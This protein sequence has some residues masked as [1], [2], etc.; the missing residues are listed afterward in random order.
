MECS[1]VNGSIAKIAGDNGIFPLVLY[2]EGHTRSDRHLC[3]DDTVPSI[4]TQFIAPHM[5]G[6]AFA[7][8]TPCNFAEKF[9][10]DGPWV[11]PFYQSMTMFPVAT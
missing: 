11:H 6:A 2:G 5:H 10:H 7:L 8:A 1:L 4:N 9:G 3:C